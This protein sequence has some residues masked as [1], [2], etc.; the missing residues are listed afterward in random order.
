MNINNFLKKWYNKK[1]EDYGSCTSP[2]YM[3]F[4]KEYKG[5]LKEIAKKNNM[6]LHSFNKNHYQ[7]SAVMQSNRTNQFYYISIS[8]VRYFNNEWADNILYRTMEHEKDWTGG[9][10]LYSS[11]ENLSQEL[12]NLDNQIFKNLSQK[13]NSQVVNQD[14]TE[15]LILGDFDNEYD[16]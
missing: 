13:D 6:N 7:F 12:L 10:N 9:T 5:V 15:K 4:Q 3:Q 14:R 2:E 11:L 1:I 16:Y 8:D